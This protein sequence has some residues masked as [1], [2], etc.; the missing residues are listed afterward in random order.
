MV[1]SALAPFSDHCLLMLSAT[2]TIPRLAIFRFNNHW[3]RIAGCRDVIASSW[4]SVHDREGTARLS[5]YLKRCRANIKS[6]QR[7][8]R[9]PI[10]VPRNCNLV[11][12]MIDLPEECQ[13]L[14]YAE[15]VL[16]FLVCDA[17][18]ELLSWPST[19]ASVGRSEVTPWVMAT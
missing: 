19:G 18:Q 1:T 7:T 10:D 14:Y 3:L 17:A 16:R 9:S 4:S 15:R 2:T 11:I 12:A 6:W 8:L 13:P 5:L